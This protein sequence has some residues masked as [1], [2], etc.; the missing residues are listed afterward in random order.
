[1]NT[2]NVLNIL[3]RHAKPATRVVVLSDTHIWRNAAMA[4]PKAFCDD[5]Y[6]ADVIIHGGDLTS[7]SVVD[8][9]KGL[10]NTVYAVRGNNDLGSVRLG[11]KSVFELPE[12]LDITIEGVRI[13]VN[14]GS[15]SYYDIP[16]R[17]SRR[18]QN[19]GFD[20]IIFG[21]S[22]RVHAQKEMVGGKEALFLNPGS[23]LEP[24]TGQATYAVLE[25]SGDKYICRHKYI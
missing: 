2:S 24:R 10:S 25:I 14:H 15:G 18:Y 17:L 12:D 1:M 23:L 22:H 5:A 4:M 19:N 13:G 7:G 21:H 6:G 3:T 16:Q 20:I 9:L 11:D 8:Q